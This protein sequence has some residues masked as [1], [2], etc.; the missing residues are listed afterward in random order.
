MEALG[1]IS[2]DLVFM[3][4]QMPGMSGYEAT[5]AIRRQEQ[6]SGR[7]SKW[8]CPVHIVAVTANAMEGDREKCLAAGMD[9]YLSKPIRLQ[10]IR[11]V[12]ERWRRATQD[13]ITAVEVDSAP[14][15]SVDALETLPVSKNQEAAPVDMQALI[16]ASEGPEEVRE[17]IDLYLHQSNL[18]MENIRLAIR[19][20]AAEEVERYAHKLYGAS[21]NC[22]ITAILSPLRE[23]ENMGQSG[24]ITEAERLYTEARRQ[25]DRIED[26][27]RDLSL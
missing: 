20:G 27:L 2:Y 14:A 5:R 6:S 23:L 4:C 3:D 19:S 21:A 7:D 13:S 15:D 16:E 26:Y 11:A 17:L 8:K 25:L 22:R 12:L 18:L 9:D 10:D 24:Q 1:S